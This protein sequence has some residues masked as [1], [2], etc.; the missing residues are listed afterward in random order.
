MNINLFASLINI[1]ITHNM[2]QMYIAFSY[3]ILFK[4]N[5][6]NCDEVMRYDVTQL[7]DSNMFKQFKNLSK[8][9]LKE[10]FDNFN[11]HNQIKHFINL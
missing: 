3:Q 8:V 10:L 7:N 11:T 9:F 5:E 2:K 4:N 6:S 1:I